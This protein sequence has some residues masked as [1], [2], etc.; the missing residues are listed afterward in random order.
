MRWTVGLWTGRLVIRAGFCAAFHDTRSVRRSFF[1]VSLIYGNAASGWA[2]D[3][4]CMI[5][6]SGFCRGVW[7]VY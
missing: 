7:A 4:A 1:T 6:M 5:G 3:A 2:E